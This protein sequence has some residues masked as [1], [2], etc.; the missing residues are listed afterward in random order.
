M[1]KNGEEAP[2]ALKIN[3]N[4]TTVITELFRFCFSEP[5]KSE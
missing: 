4:T 3:K 1:H 2:Y 5:S